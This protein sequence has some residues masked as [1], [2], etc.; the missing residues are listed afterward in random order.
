GVGVN[1]F[2]GV[3]LS[4]YIIR[5]LGA[6]GYGLWSLLFSLVSYYTLLDF[7]IRSAIIRYSAHFR[8]TAD[9]SSIN[10]IVN[11]AV[12]YFSVTAI[13]LL[14]VTAY[15]SLSAHQFINVPSGYQAVF[16]VLVAIVGASWAFG[17]VFN[18]F[19]GGLEGFQGFDTSNRIWVIS[20]L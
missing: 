5:K 12:A 18:V 8:A 4:P 10:E 7:G 9:F 20:V 13:V 6:D 3:V 16:S 2:A 19:T 1:L 11:T 15:L 17:M 14:G